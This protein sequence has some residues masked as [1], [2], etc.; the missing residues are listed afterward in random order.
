[1]PSCKFTSCQYR[2]LCN[3]RF[4]PWI[5]WN[6]CSKFLYH[7]NQDYVSLKETTF[8][9]LNLNEN[10]FEDDG[11]GAFDYSEKN[12]KRNLLIYQMYFIDRKSVK[13]ISNHLSIPEITIYKF[14]E[15]AKKGIH[16]IINKKKRREK[17]V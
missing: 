14:I 3:R 15:R 12:E 5:D 10:T 6:I 11:V 4:D 16:K 8:A 17:S 7:I 1:M 13:Y 9:Q 2:K